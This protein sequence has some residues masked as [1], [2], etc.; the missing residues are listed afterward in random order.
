[1]KKFMKLRATKVIC[2]TFLFLHIHIYSC[3]PNQLI[4]NSYGEWETI[5]NNRSYTESLVL[6][7]KNNNTYIEGVEFKN[8]KGNAIFLRNVTNVYIKDCIIHDIDGYGIVLS[9]NGSTD[10]ITIDNCK[11]Y[12]TSQS[13]IHSKQREE[14]NIN[15]TN[16]LIK[17]NS[18]YNN[19]SHNIYI[20]STDSIIENN[21]F[22]SASSNAISI[23]SSGIIRGN[24]VWNANK[25]CIRYWSDHNAGTS[26]KL[27]IENNV[28]YLLDPGKRTS[29]I[30]LV[31][32]EIVPPDWVVNNYTI[33]FNT[34][35]LL[36]D[37]I[38]G[39]EVESSNFNDKHIEVYGNLVINS[40]NITKTISPD[41]IDVFTGNVIATTL[42]WLFNV[43]DEPYDFR[44]VGDFAQLT[45]PRDVP[46][47]P[48][49]DIIG[50]QRNSED[51]NAGAYQ[52]IK[53]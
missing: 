26:D 3:S 33:R 40:K 30:S 41:Y 42:S 14:K 9:S 37:Q 12:N 6:T 22:H 10:K 7:V 53:N 38:F 46:D 4:H 29:A 47:F 19:G 34:V 49:F 45:F 48:K 23:R 2:F 15:H 36:T 24:Q 21:I 35:I 13:G 31:W 16:L 18:I 1:M 25:A 5:I 11:I 52:Y 20:Q 44:L 51:L 17:N 32:S 8:I 27:Q 43:K 39:I 50:N 28:C